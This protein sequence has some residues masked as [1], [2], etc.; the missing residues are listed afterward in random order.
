[1]ILQQS[2]VFALQPLVRLLEKL[3]N[4]EYQQPLA[5][6][7][8]SSIGKHLRHIAEFYECLLTGIPNGVIDYDAR[9]RNPDIENN[10]D[11]AYQTLQA[12]ST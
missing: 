5:V 11:F 3:S 9:K 2:S 1:M 7:S 10:R 4:E 12:I 6:F 8:G